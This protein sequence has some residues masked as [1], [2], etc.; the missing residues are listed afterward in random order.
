MGRLPPHSTASTNDRLSTPLR[1]GRPSRP[2]RWSLI[3][4]HCASARVRPLK[5]TSVFDLEPN[6]T[7]FGNPRLRFS[8][9]RSIS[10]VAG[11]EDHV[12]DRRYRGES[13]VDMV[14]MTAVMHGG[15]RGR[16]ENDRPDPRPAQPDRRMAQ[17]VAHEVIEQRQHR[18]PQHRRLAGQDP[19]TQPRPVA[20]DQPV[21]RIVHGVFPKA[22]YRMHH[23]DAVMRL[24]KLPQWRR[25]VLKDVDPTPAAER[26]SAESAL[27]ERAAWPAGCGNAPG[28]SPPKRRD[29]EQIPA[30]Q[31][32]PA[33]SE[34]Q[35]HRRD[36]AYRDR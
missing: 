32:G 20:N 5:I 26:E 3:C 28:Q 29:R 24:V 15:M 10:P 33:P 14:G 2:G 16:R 23:L 13:P 7:R 18:Q 22:R 35:R 8:A 4:A 17:S 1:P 25:F 27:A 11:G 31:A 30:R 12:A 9:R 21:D 19:S 6:L 36:K 34:R